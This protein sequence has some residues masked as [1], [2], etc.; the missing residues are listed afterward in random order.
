MLKA[1]RD[2]ALGLIPSSWAYIPP[3]GSPNKLYLMRGTTRLN[4]LKRLVELAELP[5]N[6]A[7]SIGERHSEWVQLSLKKVERQ[8]READMRDDPS[9]LLD[10]L[11]D[12]I[13][14]PWHW[15]LY[16]ERRYAIKKVLADEKAAVD[17]Q[18]R[19]ALKYGPQW[20]QLGFNY[21][22]EAAS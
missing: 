19:I 10:Q 6:R 16:N 12:E 22:T 21:D 18:R 3:G 1:E 20:H 15:R 17:E 14:R 7:A 5:S 2:F 4:Y 8:L 13:G 9:A 11:M